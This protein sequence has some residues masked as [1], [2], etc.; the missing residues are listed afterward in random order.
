M[1]TILRQKKV[2]EI[3][4]YSPM[5]LWRLERLNKF[6]KRIKL[7]PNSVGWISTEIFEWVESKIAERDARQQRQRAA[8]DEQHDSGS[9]MP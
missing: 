5:H 4:G 8:T 3:V 1:K 2:C 9:E 6:P 7:G